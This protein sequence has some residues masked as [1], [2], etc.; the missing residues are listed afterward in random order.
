ME[1]FV[2]GRD[3]AEL[4]TLLQKLDNAFGEN[5][6]GGSIGLET[7]QQ[8]LG[9]L[10]VNYIREGKQGVLSA[11]GRS[12]AEGAE[13]AGRALKAINSIED[14][15]S[16]RLGSVKAKKVMKELFGLQSMKEYKSLLNRIHK[17]G[18]ESSAKAA[19]E[20]GTVLSF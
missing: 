19:T 5:A 18:P 1:G 13:E 7:K 8:I 11:M 3:G 6:F 14:T 15:I 20:L 17:G 4:A 10:G 9:A 12:A 16:K 2:T